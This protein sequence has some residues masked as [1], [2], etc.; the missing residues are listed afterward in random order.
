MYLLILLEAISLQFYVF[1]VVLVGDVGFY[2]ERT[3]IAVS[4][5]TSYKLDDQGLNF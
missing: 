4:K 5:V 3:E 2:N 1:R